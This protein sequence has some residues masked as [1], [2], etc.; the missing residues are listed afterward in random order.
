[1]LFI[2]K[3]CLCDARNT[4]NIFIWKNFE[5]PDSNTTELTLTAKYSDLCVAGGEIDDKK[6]FGFAVGDDC[7]CGDLTHEC[8][9]V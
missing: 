1:M 2:I 8:C 7:L 6:S 3:Y 5:F 9:K 4:T